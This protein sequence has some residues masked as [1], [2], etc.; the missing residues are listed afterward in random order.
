MPKNMGEG[1]PVKGDSTFTI[2]PSP[3]D[4]KAEKTSENAAHKKSERQIF[5]R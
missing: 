3:E 1:N 5:L 4:V 2:S